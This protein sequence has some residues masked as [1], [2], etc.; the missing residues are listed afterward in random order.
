VCQWVAKA[1]AYRLSCRTFGVLT[2]LDE[3]MSRA[4]VRLL[5]NKSAILT[6]LH[7]LGRYAKNPYNQISSIQNTQ[8]AE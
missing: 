4:F 6:L 2:L 8:Q 3:Q 1:V 7:F 5:A